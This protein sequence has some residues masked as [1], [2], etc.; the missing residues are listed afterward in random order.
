MEG[1]YEGYNA[2][3]FAYGATGAG[4]TYTMLGSEG[5]PGVMWLTIKALFE[6]IRDISSFDFKIKSSFL[7]IYNE[8]IR[9]LTNLN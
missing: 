2:T 5:N 7:E 3:V 8:N 4:K 9:D 1:L 6:K